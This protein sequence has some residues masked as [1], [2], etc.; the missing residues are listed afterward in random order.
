MEKKTNGHGGRREGSGRKKGGTN[1]F[2][3]E[4]L[5][6]AIQHKANGQPY[7]ELLAEDFAHARLNDRHLAQKYH[8]L[9]INKVA[10]SLAK[11]ETVE[12]EDMI[13]A[14]KDAF[15]EALTTMIGLNDVKQK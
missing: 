1:N 4:T 3:I 8:N 5:L 13:A 11:I 6:V 15:T 9:I 2:T 14:K 12:S 7:E 10:P